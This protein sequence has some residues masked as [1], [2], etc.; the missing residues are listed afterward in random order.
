M[1][2][3]FYEFNLTKAFNDFN[4]SPK[5]DVKIIIDDAMRFSE[6]G[7]GSIIPKVYKIS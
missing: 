2:K 7:K 4:Y 1:A 5:W 6:T 3:L